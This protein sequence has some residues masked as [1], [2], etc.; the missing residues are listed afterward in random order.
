MRRFTLSLDEIDIIVKEILNNIKNGVIV[1]KG[2]LASGKTTLVKALVKYLNIDEE[3]TSP[4]FSLQQIY[5]DKI[6]HY[7]I[8]NKELD[9]FL[10]L[11]MLEELEKDGLHLIEWGDERLEAILKN[12]GLDYITIEI[13]KISPTKREYTLC[14]H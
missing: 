8:Y 3:V 5:A 11:G 12:I 13:K 9:G 4:T 2:D 6:F 7:D 10:A 14:T 1:L